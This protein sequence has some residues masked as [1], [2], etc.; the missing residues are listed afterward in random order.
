ERDYLLPLPT[1]ELVL[2]GKLEQNPGWN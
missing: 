2:N 1:T